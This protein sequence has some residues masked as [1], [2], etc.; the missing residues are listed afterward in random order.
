MINDI[1]WVNIL[2]SIVSLGGL[3]IAFSGFILI[4]KQLSKLNSTLINDAQGRLFVQNGEIR[5]LLVEKPYMRKYFFNS[6]KISTDH[7]NYSEVRTLAEMYANYMEH[8]VL[9]ENNVN[10]NDWGL[11]TGIIRDIYSTSPILQEVITEKPKWF[12]HSLHKAIN[13]TNE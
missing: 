7:D 8:L 6:E 5:K 2:N 4:Y 9:Q 3:F 13:N 12:S 1:S 10:P 11:W